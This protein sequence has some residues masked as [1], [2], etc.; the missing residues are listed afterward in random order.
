MWWR[1]LCPCITVRLY[2]PL[3][4][5]GYNWKKSPEERLCLTIVYILWFFCNC[6]QFVWL[7]HFHASFNCLFLNGNYRRRTY[8]QYPLITV[9]TKGWGVIALSL[10]LNIAHIFH[11]VGNHMVGS[12]INV[13]V[14]AT[15]S[16]KMD[17]N[18]VR[19]WRTVLLL[20]FVAIA[21]PPS[22]G[23]TKPSGVK[24]HSNE[25]TGIVVAIHPDE[26][27]NPA[28]IDIIKVGSCVEWSMLIKIVCCILPVTEV[29]L[30]GSDI[31][32]EQLVQCVKKTGKI[33]KTVQ[34][35]CCGIEIQFP[36]LCHVR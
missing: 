4:D 8:I 3:L 11:I 17:E 26:P 27:E 20:I 24:L 18:S 5:I 34:C 28:I 13:T 21:V 12:S 29:L 32:R 6:L 33:Y 2:H 23:L 19:H 22:S 30:V 35:L 9:Q 7:T 15:S 31:F 36:T 14:D 25:Y 1:Q 16:A 10:L